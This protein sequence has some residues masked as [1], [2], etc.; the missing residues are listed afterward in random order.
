MDKDKILEK[1]RKENR[2]QDEFSADV[3]KKVQ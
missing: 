2:M 3:I 1:S